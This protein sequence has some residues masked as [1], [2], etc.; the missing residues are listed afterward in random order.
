MYGGLRDGKSFSL[1]EVAEAF[2]I[3]RHHLVK[4]V[5]RL[6]RLGYLQTRRGRSGG[7]MLSRKPADIKIGD[8]VRQTENQPAI[9]ECFDPKG[10]GCSINGVCLLKGAL[11]KAVMSFYDSLNK[12]TLQDLVSGPHKARMAAVLLKDD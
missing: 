12:H 3:S 7:I 8:L 11:G 1:T 4:V 6:S 9:V 2:G 10:R 5:N